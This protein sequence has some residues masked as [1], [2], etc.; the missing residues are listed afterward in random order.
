[1]TRPLR[2]RDRLLSLGTKIVIGLVLGIAAGLFFGELCRPL[3]V[4]GDTFVALL[5]MTVLPY[6]VVA[7][8]ANVGRL[9]LAR[10]RTLLGRAAV[11]WLLLLVAGLC[12]LLF[13]S[14][15]FPDRA[16]PSFFSARLVAPPEPPDF[17]AFFVPT[18]VFQSLV[19]NAV[20]G[21]V[22][23]CI[24][25]GAAL[26]G[27]P[28][29]DS[30]IRGLD[31]VGEA[32]ARVNGFFIGLTPYGVFA[33]AAAAAGT[34]TVAEFGRLRGYLLVYSFTSLILAFWLLPMLAAACTPFRYRDILR[35]SSDALF[36]AFATSKVLVVLPMMIDRTRQLFREGEAEVPETAPCIDVLYPLAYPF[37]YLGKVLTLLFIPFAAAFVGRTLLLDDYPGLFGLGVLSLFGGPLLAIP[38]LLELN[39]LPSDMMQL[40]VLSGVYTGRVGD[41]VGV[42]NLVTFT[43]ITTC[44]LT[45]FLRIRWRVLGLVLGVG[46]GLVLAAGASSRAYLDTVK[47]SYQRDKIL[48]GMHLQSAGDTVEARVVERPEPNPVRL[49]PGQSRLERI[50]ERGVLRVGFNDDNLPYAFRNG[51]G[52]LVGLDVQMAHWLARDLGA[53]LEFVPFERGSLA[54]QISA[55]HFDIAMSG[56]VGT[57]ARSQKMK[58][59]EPYLEATFSLVVRDYRARELGD[60]ER[61]ARS[62]S[63][64]VGIL[65]ESQFTRALGFLAPRA[66]TVIVLSTRWYF[67]EA[68]DLDALILSAEAGAA[69]TILYPGFQVVVPTRH[70]IAMPMV[71]ALPDGDEDWAE[72]VDFWVSFQKGM[73]G[74]GR[75]YDYWVRGETPGGRSRRWSVL[76]NVLGD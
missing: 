25:V 45:G 9:S 61:L 74:V 34:M 40:F 16:V 64:R 73:G 18:N 14:L 50:R 26:I 51:R 8:I 22:L 31:T 59:S 39:E 68:H 2:E 58:L 49:R 38:F 60:A 41:L 52:E 43:I 48:A 63:L 65:T 62:G 30:V 46:A 24:C 76:R 32:I 44:A 29:K 66:E 4:V 69:W 27:I 33:I 11:V 20:P 37:P 47:D 1:M 53:T 17:L 3:K 56:L 6:I 70:K 36:T 15:S 55:D 42:M 5:Q 71:Y 21:V 57:L 28:N 72:F 13:M 67:E 19:T 23:F 7:L 12:V 35:T 54:A 10:G 75:L